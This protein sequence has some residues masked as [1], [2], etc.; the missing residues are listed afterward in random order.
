MGVFPG[1]VKVQLTGV[2][3]HLVCGPSLYSFFLKEGKLQVSYT[4]EYRWALSLASGF[5]LGIPPSRVD[6]CGGPV[7]SEGAQN[8]SPPPFSCG[9]YK[10]TLSVSGLSTTHA[11]P[12]GLIITA[13]STG[14]EYSPHAHTRLRQA[15]CKKPGPRVTCLHCWDR[16]AQGL[17]TVYRTRV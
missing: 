7:R 11:R 1:V 3:C 17:Q 12:A 5:S 2:E 9:P 13:G 16:R 6:F 4:D 15:D 8:T 14:M 10:S